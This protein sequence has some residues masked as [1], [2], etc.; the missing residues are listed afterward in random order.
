[1]T[2][3]PGP[4]DVLRQE[5]DR[6]NETHERVSAGVGE[7]EFEDFQRFHVYRF[8]LSPSIDA[9]ARKEILRVWHHE[10]QEYPGKIFLK[11]EKEVAYGNWAELRTIVKEVLDSEDVQRII[12]SLS[13]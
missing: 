6:F 13:V 10:S 3:L 9:N 5:A 7:R 1:M 2:S 4:H 11:G 8:F 12:E